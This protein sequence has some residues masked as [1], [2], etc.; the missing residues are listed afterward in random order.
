MS[1]LWPWP[2]IELIGK[3]NTLICPVNLLCWTGLC[4]IQLFKCQFTAQP[5]FLPDGC[6]TH[7]LANDDSCLCCHTRTSRYIV[8]G[9]GKAILFLLTLQ[10]NNTSTSRFCPNHEPNLEATHVFA[11]GRSSKL[12]AT[13][14]GAGWARCLS[15]FSEGSPDEVSYWSEDKYR[16][17]E[18]QLGWFSMR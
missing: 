4:A 8:L 18:P 14:V 13:T 15:A 5:P 3:R 7:Y 11:T 10:Y 12:P 16:R 1:G 6:A 9:D 2:D 17:L